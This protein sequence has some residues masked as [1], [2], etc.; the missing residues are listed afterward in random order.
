MPVKKQQECAPKTVWQML[1]FQ[2]DPGGLLQL[3]NNDINQKKN[4]KLKSALQRIEQIIP[5]VAKMICLTSCHML[6]KSM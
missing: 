4:T 5:L 2:H 6:K 3:L 1:L